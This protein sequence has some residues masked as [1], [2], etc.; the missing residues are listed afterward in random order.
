MGLT[1]TVVSGEL[2]Q[3]AWGNEI[4]DRTVQVF[5]TVAERDS[6]W[7]DA[8]AGAVCLTLDTGTLWHRASA[9]WYQRSPYLVAEC[10][11]ATDKQTAT[12]TPGVLVATVVFTVGPGRRCYR[13]TLQAQHQR[14]GVGGL[15][16]S[17]V[18]VAGVPNPNIIIQT[19]HE[20]LGGP[21][22]EHSA[23]V[24]Y[25]NVDSGSR[26]GEYWLSAPTP[27]TASW[28]M[29]GSRIYFEDVGPANPLLDVPGE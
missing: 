10:R 6:L 17:Y 7:P 21:G 11:L 28:A 29:A 16:R 22:H 1:P 3:A 12:G 2:I 23:A 15:T 4:R 25:F 13:A 26:T 19:R 9:V 27:S 8:P 24:G 14:S 18:G 5:A 20:V